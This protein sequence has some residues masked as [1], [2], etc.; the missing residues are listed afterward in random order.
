[1]QQVEAELL[2]RSIL[3]NYFCRIMWSHGVTETKNMALD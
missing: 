2:S 1:M 3:Q